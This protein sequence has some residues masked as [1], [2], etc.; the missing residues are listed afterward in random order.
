MELIH[1]EH[2]TKSA[3]SHYLP[4]RVSYRRRK[5]AVWRDLETRTDDFG[6]HQY[7][8]IELV[9]YNANLQIRYLLQ[10]I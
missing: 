2:F 1:A 7:R 3:G 6:T 10:R 9:Q 4:N 5:I 8:A